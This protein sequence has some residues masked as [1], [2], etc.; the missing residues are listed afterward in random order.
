M[1]NYDLIKQI[2]EAYEEYAHHGYYQRRE[3]PTFDKWVLSSGVELMGKVLT[4]M[5][6]VEQTSNSAPISP[7]KPKRKHQEA[8]E[9]WTGDKQKCPMCDKTITPDVK[10]HNCG[11]GLIEPEN[12]LDRYEANVQRIAEEMAKNDVP[13]LF[14]PEALSKK[15][16]NFDR[17]QL[18]K[19]FI[20]PARIAIN[21]TAHE[22]VDS[23]MKDA[24]MTLNQAT[25]ILRERGL[26]PA[27]EGES[28]EI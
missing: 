5:H 11:Q 25:C 12:K 17:E 20:K 10:C 21:K 9:F 28:H 1:A 24:G 16:F 2:A 19:S 3:H 22:L 4:H 13:K 15:A 23:L 14:E 7:D 27:Q 26:I 8:Y 6:N 18:I